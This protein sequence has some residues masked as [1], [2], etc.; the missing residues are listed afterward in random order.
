MLADNG[1]IR[2]V[3]DSGLVALIN[4]QSQRTTIEYYPGGIPEAQLLD[5]HMVTLSRPPTI[6]EVALFRAA[7]EQAKIATALIAS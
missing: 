5:W 3:H 4:P 7:V 1:K 6:R 2:L